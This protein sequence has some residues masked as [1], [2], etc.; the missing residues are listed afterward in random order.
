LLSW[1]KCAV[2]GAVCLAL[3]TGVLW[4]LV[5]TKEVDAT[6]AETSWIRS[7][8]IDQLGP[9]EEGW[10]RPSDAVVLQTEQRQRV[11][12]VPVTVTRT[13]KATKE[14][15][16]G[17]TKK[18][19]TGRKVDAGD[20][21]M[22]NEEKEVPVTKTVIY[23]EEYQE[24]E[25][26]PTVV[27]ATWYVYRV[28]RKVRTEELSGERNP[29]WPKVTLLPEQRTSNQREEFSVVFLT[30]GGKTHQHSPS[31]EGEFQ[32]FEKGSKRRLMV[33]NVG[34]LISVQ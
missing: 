16:T 14:V 13:R 32:Q 1:R 7:I 3:I 27:T 12:E 31:D 33:N 22:R 34:W 8:Q 10:D 5:G 2:F 18:V 17:E 19:K 30:T 29:R 25:M 23:D 21:S 6:V 20:G 28:W 4:L 15:P 9:R 26:R 24:T 11:Q